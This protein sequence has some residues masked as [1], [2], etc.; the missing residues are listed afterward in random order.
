MFAR[1]CTLFKLAIFSICAKSTCFKKLFSPGDNNTQQFH[2][3]AFKISIPSFFEKSE[4]FKK[5]KI[6]KKNCLK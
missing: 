2:F 3:K 5:L 4:Q 6:I 1:S